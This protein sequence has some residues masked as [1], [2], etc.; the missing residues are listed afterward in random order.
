MSSASACCSTLNTGCDKC[1]PVMIPSSWDRGT[2]KLTPLLFRRFHWTQ[3]PTYFGDAHT[4]IPAN[5]GKILQPVRHPAKLIS[6]VP[7]VAR[8]ICTR[9]RPAGAWDQIA[10]KRVNSHYAERNI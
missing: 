3:F 8:F 5:T 6:L 7:R 4:E 10:Q 9:K 1:F 2:L